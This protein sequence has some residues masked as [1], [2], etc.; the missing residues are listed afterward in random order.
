MSD[1]IAD[2]QIGQPIR[3]GESSKNYCVVVPGQDF[4]YWISYRFI[5][6]ELQVCLVN[7]DHNVVAQRVKQLEKVVGAAYGARRVVRR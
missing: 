7:D 4:S 3:L 6:D 1:C 5:S 2:P